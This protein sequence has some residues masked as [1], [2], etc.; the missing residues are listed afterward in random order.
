[1]P[2]TR[3]RNIRKRVGG[4]SLH[5]SVA[6]VEIVQNQSF[7]AIGAKDRADDSPLKPVF[8]LPG[9]EIGG[10]RAALKKRICRY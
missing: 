9:W 5:R 7:G 4:N 8:S 10:R 3:E 2:L 1:M 6:S